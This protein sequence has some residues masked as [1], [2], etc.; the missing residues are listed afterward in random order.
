MKS[1]GLGGTRLL[2]PTVILTAILLVG[3]TALAATSPAPSLADLPSHSTFAVRGTILIDGNSEFTPSN[4]VVSGSGTPLDPYIIENWEINAS[5]AI[6]IEIRNTN[7]HFSIRNVTVQHGA[8]SYDGIR[9][10]NLSHGSVGAANL[11][12]NNFGIFLMDVVDISVSS[13]SISSGFEGIHAEG[14]R[15]SS[16]TD[17]SFQTLSLYAIE[18]HRSSNVTILRATVTAQ[19]YGIAF[20][21][22]EDVSVE[23]SN[24]TG[25]PGGVGIVVYDVRRF[26][27][28]GNYVSNMGV[29]VDSGFSDQGTIRGN[30]L[31]RNGPAPNPILDGAG[32]LVR[33]ASD[34]T[35]LENDLEE[36]DY[37]ISVK[38]SNE[39]SI[40]HNRFVGNANQ[41]VDDSNTINAWDGGY[42]TGGNVWSDYGG[43]DDCRGPSQEDCSQGDGLGDFPYDVPSTLGIQDR[44]PLVPV[45]PPNEP[46]IAQFV[47]SP[48]PHFTG[49]AVWFDGS[50]SHDPDDRDTGSLTY[51][52]RFGDD[53]QDTTGPFVVH[54][55]ATPGPHSV[56][57]EVTDR[58]D[59][60]SSSNVLLTIERPPA[61]ALVLLEHPAGFRLEVPA[62]WTRTLNRS[63]GDSVVELELEGSYRSA[64][65]T[66]L[67]DAEVDSTARE[68]RPYLQSFVDTLISELRKEL[69]SAAVEGSPEYRTIAGHSSV[70]FVIAYGQL[71]L[72]QK[73]ALVVSEDHSRYWFFLLTGASTYFAPL[74]DAFDR[75][76]LSFEITLPRVPRP[77]SYL[78]V[79]GLAGAAAA[80]LGAVGVVLWRRRKH[81]RT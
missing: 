75:M 58:R 47:T 20:F 73:A 55:Y 25:F 23:L 63:D 69:P 80:V 13:T 53:S 67:V 37:G 8:S 42:P 46:P 74:S 12:D 68:S 26:L 33:Y 39:V 71:P 41:G 56:T 40:Y 78:L 64:L 1:Y 31:L 79:L 43:W 51:H 54:T 16:F 50:S 24:I 21:D 17:V 62:D 19:K 70:A 81:P 60:T 49:E 52:W 9:F 3:S 59:G 45:N 30:S 61:I 66:I 14:I 76:L 6:G 22:G 5:E 32:I 28:A 44:Y 36:N 2:W 72:K 65:A 77:I 57:L 4:G 48:G 7:A 18:A 15:N 34:I 27:V 29:G 11:S 35:V 38:A 10:T